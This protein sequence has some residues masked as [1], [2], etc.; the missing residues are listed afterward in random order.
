M[1]RCFDSHPSVRLWT[2][3]L[4]I[5]TAKCFWLFH[6][7]G[8]NCEIEGASWSERISFFITIMSVG[9]HS[10]V[11][12]VVLCFPLISCSLMCDHK[13]KTRASAC[14]D[15]LSCKSELSNLIPRV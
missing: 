13:F 12:P 7:E 6:L 9:V 2:L 4:V 5:K 3:R 14:E 11:L 15:I 10:I 1:I 8:P